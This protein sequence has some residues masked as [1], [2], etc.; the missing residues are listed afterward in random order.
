MLKLVLPLVFVVLA[1]GASTPAAPKTEKTKESLAEPAAKASAPADESAG[2]PDSDSGADAEDGATAETAGAEDRP[3]KRPPSRKRAPTVKKPST[4]PP[5]IRSPA[6]REELGMAAQGP[7]A[8]LSEREQLEALSLD[9]ARSRE[10][11]RVETARL[12]QL[13]ADVESKKAAGGGPAGVQPRSGSGAESGTMPIGSPLAALS[14]LNAEPPPSFGTQ[15]MVVSKAM[16]GMKP[17]KA[18]AIMAHLDRTLAAEVLQRMPS[19]DAGEILGFLKPELGALLAS[20]IVNRPPVGS[21]KNKK[22]KA[23]P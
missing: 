6:L 19:A 11:L 15:V 12:E 13:M 21:G 23:N 8:N 1:D 4:H 5:S 16:K 2:T 17:E 3:S 10:A 9:L 22:G 20:E 7:K 18:A 14:A